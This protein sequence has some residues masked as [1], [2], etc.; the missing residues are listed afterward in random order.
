MDDSLLNNQLQSY[1]SFENI[2]SICLDN[3]IFYPAALLATPDNDSYSDIELSDI[4]A[5]EQSENLSV[6]T[7]ENSDLISIDLSSEDN[8]RHNSINNLWICNNCDNT[9][10]LNCISKWGKNK[11]YFNCPICRKKHSLQITEINTDIT[12]WNKDCID[13]LLFIIASITFIIIIF[14]ILFI[15][16]IQKKYNNN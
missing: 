7:E 3:M 11:L 6:I 16:W 10:H 9:F 14:L 4:E 15:P 5:P 2:C 1:K 12:V 8:S 13:L